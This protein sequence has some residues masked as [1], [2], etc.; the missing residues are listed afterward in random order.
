[1]YQTP[2]AGPDFDYQIDLYIIEED[3]DSWEGI[4][5]CT[6]KDRTR[7]YRFKITKDNFELYETT[8]LSEKKIF[9]EEI[10]YKKITTS[11]SESPIIIPLTIALNMQIYGF[12]MREIID[13]KSVTTMWGGGKLTNLTLEGPL[14]YNKYHS[15]KIIGEMI[16]EPY[17]PY[18]STTTYYVST[19]PPYLLI[20]QHTSIGPI[21]NYAIISLERVEKE[22]FDVG[23]YNVSNPPNQHPRPKFSYSID[24]LTAEF[25][26]SG[27]YDP[28][29][30]ITQYMWDFGDGTNGT[31]INP[32]HEYVL[33]GSYTVR[34]TVTDDEGGSNLIIKTITI[35]TSSTNEEDNENGSND[36]SNDGKDTSTPGFEL[37]FIVV[38]IAFV[39]FWKRYKL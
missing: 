32:T 31:G 38:A 2:P 23:K 1:M 16:N 22:S 3:E 20:D 34:L 8:Q 7:L 15:Y 29:G 36:S 25:N 5:A 12:D 13:N 11:S 19:V 14:D 33:S 21:E 4:T 39:L 37:V 10:H 27:S 26:A 9:D 30:K 17:E 28:D 18:T 35:N 24:N 6:S